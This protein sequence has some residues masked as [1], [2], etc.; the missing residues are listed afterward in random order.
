MLT[1]ILVLV[2]KADLSTRA[3]MPA[4]ALRGRDLGVAG[5][6]AGVCGV[7]SPASCRSTVRGRP[8]P[9]LGHVA[10]WSMDSMY[11]MTH[12]RQ[13]AWPHC[14]RCV[15]EAMS[16]GTSQITHQGPRLSSHS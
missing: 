15:V 3:M 2:R 4:R 8:H 5:V 7:P 9:S 14:G 12:R 13:K 11:S 10:L 6:A 1:S 16:F